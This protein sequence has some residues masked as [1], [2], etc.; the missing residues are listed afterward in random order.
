MIDNL[1]QC[2]GL[3]MLLEF[4]PIDL[5]G[6]NEYNLFHVSDYAIFHPSMKDLTRKVS[7]LSL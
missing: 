7:Y 3:N 4:K 1:F 2:D 6:F 5:I